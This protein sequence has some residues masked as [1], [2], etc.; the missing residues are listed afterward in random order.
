MLFDAYG[1]ALGGANDVG[2][3][4]KKLAKLC[5]CFLASCRDERVQVSQCFSPSPNKHIGVSGR[6]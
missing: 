5:F 3:F 2:C 1:P 4:V 6:A